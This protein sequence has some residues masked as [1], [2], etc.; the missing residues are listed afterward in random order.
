VPGLLLGSG[1]SGLGAGR[2]ADQTPAQMP[3]KVH[4][5]SRALFGDARRCAQADERQEADELRAGEEAREA[6]EAGELETAQSEGQPAVMAHVHSLAGRHA[7]PPLKYP[8]TSETTFIPWERMDA[9]ANSPLPAPPPAPPRAPQLPPAP[10]RA[11]QPPPALHRPS[12]PPPALH[13][14]SQPP[15]ALHRRSQPPPAQGV[16]AG[17]FAPRSEAAELLSP[18]A[19]VGP[20]PE[21]D[22]GLGGARDGGDGDSA[23]EGRGPG[24]H[25]APADPAL[26]T[27]HSA[28]APPPPQGLP[29]ARRLQVNGLSVVPCLCRKGGA[30]CNCASCLT[31]RTRSLRSASFCTCTPTEPAIPLQHLAH[32]PARLTW[33]QQARRCIFFAKRN[34]AASAFRRRGWSLSHEIRP[35]AHRRPPPWRPRGTPPSAVQVQRLGDRLS[36]AELGSQV[37]PPATRAMSFSGT[38]GRVKRGPGR[39]GVTGRGGGK[40]GEQTRSFR[41]RARSGELRS[42][43]ALH[44][45]EHGIEQMAEVLTDYQCEPCL[46]YPALPALISFPALRRSGGCQASGRDRSMWVACWVGAGPAHQRPGGGRQSAA[47]PRTCINNTVINFVRA[48]ATGLHDGNR[49]WAASCAHDA[50]SEHGRSP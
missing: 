44:V 13:R 39:G 49:P 9:P 47:M 50:A 8:P 42:L 30:R 35:A 12:E 17:P 7:A 20:L 23:S 32:L 26:A 3:L 37:A 28:I 31:L 16:A 48:S 5:Q 29:S 27:A 19:G 38:P 24:E 18:F 10:P 1:W 34:K 4:A 33:E 11:P 21:P 45:Y 6:A 25:A 43:M 41:A 14:R 15:P 2:G 36:L 22:L 40:Q 46:S